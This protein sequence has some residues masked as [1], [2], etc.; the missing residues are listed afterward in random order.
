M[1]DRKRDERLELKI[2]VHGPGKGDYPFRAV[3][4]GTQHNETGT[5]ADS[6]VAALRVHLTQYGYTPEQVANLPVVMVG[7]HA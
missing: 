7:R 5:T 1:S 3:L 4:D 2:H 6:A